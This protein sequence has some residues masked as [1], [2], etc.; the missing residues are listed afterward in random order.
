M[1]DTSEEARGTSYMFLLVS[2]FVAFEGRESTSENKNIYIYVL[3]DC[4]YCI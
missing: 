3:F 4:S 2:W 1:K